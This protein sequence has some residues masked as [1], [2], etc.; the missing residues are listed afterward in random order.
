MS[1]NVDDVNVQI[2]ANRIDEVANIVHDLLAEVCPAI[3]HRHHNS[4]N[5]DLIVRA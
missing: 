4:T 3:E 2:V 1:D 5:F